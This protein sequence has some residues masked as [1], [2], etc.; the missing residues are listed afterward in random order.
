MLVYPCIKKSPHSTTKDL[1]ILEFKDNSARN[2]V[3]TQLPH[4]ASA[5]LRIIRENPRSRNARIKSHMHRWKE[6]TGE[7]D[8]SCR[9]ESY[10]ARHKE[11]RIRALHARPGESSPQRWIRS[12]SSCAARKRIPKWIDLVVP[13]TLCLVFCLSSRGSWESQRDNWIVVTVNRHR[14]RGRKREKDRWPL[15]FHEFLCERNWYSLFR[16]H[17]NGFDRQWNRYGRENFDSW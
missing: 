5:L 4:N 11:P 10:V 7:R 2:I 17:T 1:K 15:D 6:C 3:S 8:L 16:F 12:P 13:L 9:F 14:D